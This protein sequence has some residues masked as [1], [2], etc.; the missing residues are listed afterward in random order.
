[1]RRYANLFRYALVA[2]ILL[3]AT[4]AG[5][6]LPSHTVRAGGDPMSAIA[7]AQQRVM[8]EFA[9]SGT[10]RTCGD[11]ARPCRTTVDETCFGP[12]F[13]CGQAG[14]SDLI[15]WQPRRNPRSSVRGLPASD[16]VAEIAGL[17]ETPPPRA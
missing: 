15:A 4:L 10:T 13:N 7:E 6:V 5:A 14:F 3:A 11:L 8:E 2:L 12:S 1:M 17:V 9:S 16:R